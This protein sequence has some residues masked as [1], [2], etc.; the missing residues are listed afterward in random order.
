M[1]VI[2]LTADGKKIAVAS[3]AGPASYTTGGFP[4]RVGELSR[5]DQVLFAFITGGYKIGGLT[6]SGNSVTVVVHYY[7]Y[8]GA[9]AGPAVEVAAATDLS[10]QTVTLVVIGV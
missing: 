7:N 2:A 8:P 1:T 9:A 4:V 6:V 5:I 10:A 3:A